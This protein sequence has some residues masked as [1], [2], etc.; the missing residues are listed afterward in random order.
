[1]DSPG[2]SWKK[3]REAEDELSDPE[4]QRMMDSPKPSKKKSREAED[5]LSDADSK[6]VLDSPG[7]SWKKSRKA[8]DELSDTDSER[9]MDSPGPSWKN[10]RESDG[11]LFYPTSERPNIAEEFKTAYESLGDEVL[12]MVIFKRTHIACLKKFVDRLSWH[13]DKTFPNVFD[14]LISTLTENSSQENEDAV[15]EGFLHK[16]VQGQAV[17]QISEELTMKVNEWIKEE[18][19]NDDDSE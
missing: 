19:D 5:E 18:S 8:E 6:R 12:R 4:I 10:S 17:K 3:L 2:P 11:Q 14:S 16:L 7:P 13:G 1:M 9:V 15:F